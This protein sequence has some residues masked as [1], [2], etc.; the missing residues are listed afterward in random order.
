M[1]LKKI[2]FLVKIIPDIV[3]K[4]FLFWWRLP[5]VARIYILIS[6]LAFGYLGIM[7]CHSVEL[8]YLTA[9]EKTAVVV[10]EDLTETIDRDQ[11]YSQLSEEFLSSRPGYVERNKADR[12]EAI[13]KLLDAVE[14]AI[15]SVKGEEKSE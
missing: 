8:K 14:R 12:R 3:S 5:I 7:G 13:K 10:A 6:L 2:I 15:L 1:D 9:I 11:A 4:I